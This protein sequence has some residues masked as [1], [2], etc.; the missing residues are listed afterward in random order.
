MSFVDDIKSKKIDV[1]EHTKEMLKKAKTLQEHHHA[2][3]VITEELALQQAEKIKKNPQ[4]K[5]AGVCITI[6]DAI[7]VKDIETTASSAILKGYKP[8]FNA[9]VVERLE[10]EGAIILG[11]TVQDEFGFGGFSVN[12]GIGYTIPTNPHDSKRSCGGSSGGAGAASWSLGPT[13]VA[14]GESTGGSIAS[15]AAYCGV[16]GLCPTY[17][18]VSRYGLL[19]YGNS[20]DKIGPMGQDPELVA[21]VLE[22]IAG[23][24]EKESTSSTEKVDVYHTHVRKGAKGM[25]IG[26]LRHGGVDPEI[27]KE[28]NIKLKEWEGQGAHLV[29]I[30]L[31]TTMHFGL[32]TYYVL[33]M[34]EASTN[35]AKYCG[36]R[37]G[38]SEPIEGL[39]Y[40]DYF[41]AV[42][43][44]YL[45]KEAKRRIMLGTFARMAGQRDAY[46]VQAA[47]VR[48]AI[49]KEYKATFKKVDVLVSP[50]SPIMAPTFEEI[51]RLTP[52][53]HYLMDVL[54]VGPNLAGIPHLNI[55]L[56]TKIPSGMLIMADHFKESEVLKLV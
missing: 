10:Q 56:N 17:G 24:D 37:Y 22:V 38:A 31:P 51:K 16:Y 48:A 25:K 29:E 4:G 49:I 19:D 27:D 33:A 20:L 2:F 18:R 50:T 6:K 35:L 26:V 54:T 43:S 28:F 52:L 36:M 11:K 23:H 14:L 34:S 1:V 53:Q 47:R 8:V 5:L 45:G 44:K 9:T 40:N 21:L 7:C 12:V 42:R 15:P 30:A 13:H 46:Y 41:T 55:P 32:A 3:T 39:S